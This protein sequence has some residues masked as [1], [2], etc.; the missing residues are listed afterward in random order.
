MLIKVKLKMSKITIWW[1]QTNVFR[2]CIWYSIW[3]ILWF[4]KSV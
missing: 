3:Y 4:R 2:P 1:P